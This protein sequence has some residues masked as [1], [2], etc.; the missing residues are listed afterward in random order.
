M[1]SIY[2]N[3]SNALASKR[4]GSGRKATSGSGSKKRGTVGSS[5]D[6]SLNI[7]GMFNI[8]AAKH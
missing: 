1:T 8:Q 2:N 4:K 6:E 7:N 3:S 5:F